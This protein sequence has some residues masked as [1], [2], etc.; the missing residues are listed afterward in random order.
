MVAA[1]LQAVMAPKA[2][3]KPMVPE[4]AYYILEAALVGVVPGY[5]MAVAQ[6]QHAVRELAETLEENGCEVKFA[7]HP[8]L[9][10]CRDT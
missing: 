5:G 9:V 10:A 1:V 4:D 6:A 7:I 8:S 3:A 2:K